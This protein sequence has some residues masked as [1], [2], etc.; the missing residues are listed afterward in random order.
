MK[1][2]PL[3]FPT[4]ASPPTAGRVALPACRS[5]AYV[6]ARVR[7]VVD[8]S[9]GGTPVHQPPTARWQFVGMPF[10]VSLWW[11][12]PSAVPIRGRALQRLALVVPNS[13]ALPWCV[14]A[15]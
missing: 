3:F 12:P 7:T 6:G 9:A 11:C 13:S 15:D 10:S 14:S 2:H 4:A 5:G 1:F 8:V